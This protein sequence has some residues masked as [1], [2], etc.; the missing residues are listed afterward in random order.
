M[1][2]KWC[3]TTHNKSSH[4]HI[5]ICSISP[6]YHLTWSIRMHLIYNNIVLGASKSWMHIGCSVPGRGETGHRQALVCPSWDRHCLAAPDPA[7]RL[8][9]LF[10]NQVIKLSGVH[11]VVHVSFIAPSI[12]LGFCSYAV[13]W[14]LR[15]SEIC[16]ALFLAKKAIMA[17]RIC[18]CCFSTFLFWLIYIS[19]YN[20]ALD[21]LINTYNCFSATLRASSK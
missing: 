7:L 12:R 9:S 18:C 1:D 14:F 8:P 21:L 19:T 10:S 2:T 6:S 5:I 16:P 20:C 17:C 15:H 3:R 4:H 11:F 13:V